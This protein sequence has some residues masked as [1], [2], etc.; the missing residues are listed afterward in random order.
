MFTGMQAI[1]Y[2]SKVQIQLGV[3]CSVATGSLKFEIGKQSTKSLI[4]T[5]L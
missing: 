1:G 4:H 3:M 5:I 2:C